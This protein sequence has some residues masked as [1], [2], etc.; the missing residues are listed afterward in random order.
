MKSEDAFNYVELW[1]G[2]QPAT[3]S[4]AKKNLDLAERI[5]AGRL[6]AAACKLS[7]LALHPRYIIDITH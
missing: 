3:N 2:D 1:W 6:Q 5:A 7:E 4:C